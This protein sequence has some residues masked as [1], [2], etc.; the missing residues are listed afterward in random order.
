MRS[1]SAAS[2]ILVKDW[3]RKIL[4]NKI[5]PTKTREKQ[6]NKGMIKTEWLLVKMSGEG[7]WDGYEEI[8]FPSDN[9]GA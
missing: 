5:D 2:N 8:K 3:T 1:R 4:S 9:L 7:G 6:V